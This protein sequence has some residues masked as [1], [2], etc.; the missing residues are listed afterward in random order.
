[1]SQ[2]PKIRVFLDSGA[3]SAWTKKSEIPLKDYIAFIKRYRHLIHSYVSLDVI[4]GLPAKR[5]INNFIV[6]GRDTKQHKYHKIVEA[7]AAKSYE[8]HCRMLDAGLEP[9]PVYHQD[10]NIKWLERLIEDGN[11]YIGISPYAR[12]HKSEVRKFLDESFSIVCDAKGRPRVKTHGFG[13]TSSDF[14]S[15]VPWY[16]V[17]ST[18]W[19]L[20][21]A[22][23][24]ILVPI[25]G[26]DGKPDYLQR[27]LTVDVT[28][29]RID[30]RRQLDGW[31]YTH[32]LYYDCV[33]RFLND[34]GLSVT[35]VRNVYGARVY[36]VLKY[37][38]G[39]EASCQNIV[40]K[41]RRG[42]TV[43]SKHLAQASS[44]A[45]RWKPAFRMIYAAAN[46]VGLSVS[47]NACGIGDRLLSYYE[48][49]DRPEGY[50]ENYQK[51]GLPG[52]LR[53]GPNQ[54]WANVHDKSNRILDFVARVQARHEYMNEEH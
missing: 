49:R 37:F 16:S 6:G 30:A 18:S 2:P 54:R 19:K 22:Y 10:E 12:A 7:T 17:D 29:T 5:S 25:Y 45:P 31:A 26:P 53:Q 48:L 28:G 21:G 9:I 36:A 8:N 38:R 1:M 46:A 51:T 34:C 33:L 13:V 24:A 50:L 27:P 43:E 32:P 20:K 15:R 40:F 44:P 39:L 35:E 4:P 52:E 11:Q 23:G 41:H 14:I 47:L 3:Y 42:Q